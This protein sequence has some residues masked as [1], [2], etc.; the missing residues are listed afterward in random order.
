MGALD[1]SF[2]SLWPT[3]MGEN[4]WGVF[5]MGRVAVFWGDR[6]AFHKKISAQYTAVV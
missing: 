4:K 5:G 6:V 1:A 3:P 2:F